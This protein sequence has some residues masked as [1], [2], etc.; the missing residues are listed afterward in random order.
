MYMY[1]FDFILYIFIILKK[2]SVSYINVKIH[3]VKA[4]KNKLQRLAKKLNNTN[5]LDRLILPLETSQ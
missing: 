4:R 1:I 5:I 3:L 2:F